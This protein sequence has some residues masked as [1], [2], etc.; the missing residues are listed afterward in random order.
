MAFTI[1]HTFSQLAQEAKLVS[2]DEN[3]SSVASAINVVIEG[4]G[5]PTGGI[6]MWSGTIATIPAGWALCDGSN[7]TPDLRNRFIAGAG[8]IYAVGATGG[9]ANAIV[10]QHNH[11]ITDPG[12][13]HT[14][15]SR[16]A[17]GGW[18]NAAGSSDPGNRTTDTKTTGISINDRGVS[19]TNANLP[20][21]FALAYIMKL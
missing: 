5:V 7:G 2:L 18:D 10:V 9:S 16:V 13:F 3:F 20:P 1:P 17:G 12:H 4:G 19:G 6:I 8:S 21:Y 11:T 15:A 14:V